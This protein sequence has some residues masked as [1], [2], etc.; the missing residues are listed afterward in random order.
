MRYLIIL[1]SLCCLG[2]NPDDGPPNPEWF[3]NL[4]VFYFDTDKDQYPDLE[5]YDEEWLYYAWTEDKYCEIYE[6]YIIYANTISG[7]SFEVWLAMERWHSK[8]DYWILTDNTI[9]LSI[10]IDEAPCMQNGVYYN[11]YGLNIMPYYAVD[12]IGTLIN[13]Q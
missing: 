5:D 3:E 11:P 1:L 10:D 2:C 7:V 12:A 9:D 13:L 6:D 4:Y 8:P